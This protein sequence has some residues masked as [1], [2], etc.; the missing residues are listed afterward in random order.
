MMALFFFIAHEKG[1]QFHAQLQTDQILN[2]PD[3]DT[4]GR[5]VAWGHNNT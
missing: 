2:I 5:I 3:R 1:C 4:N